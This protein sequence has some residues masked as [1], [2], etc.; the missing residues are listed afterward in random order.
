MFVERRNRF[1][2][3]LFGT[4]KGS[5]AN[6]KYGF[7]LLFYLVFVVLFARDA[8]HRFISGGQFI[9]V[10]ALEF[11]PNTDVNESLNMAYKDPDPCV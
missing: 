8:P 4:L 3:K 10:A 11:T 2:L 1:V 6:K 9:D 5:L 7:P